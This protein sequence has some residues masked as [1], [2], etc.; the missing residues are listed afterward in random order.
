MLVGR[1]MAELKERKICSGGSVLGHEI[2]SRGS[3]WRKSRSK[4]SRGWEWEME[5]LRG[6]E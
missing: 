4:G 2:S 1:K 3:L 5:P 6:K